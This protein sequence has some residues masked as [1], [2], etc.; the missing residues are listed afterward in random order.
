[1]KPQ[2]FKHEDIPY[3]TMWPD[4]KLWYSLMLNGKYFNGHFKF[5]GLTK[6]LD[7]NIDEII[8]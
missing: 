4:D 3:D 8:T 2:W 7:Y 5:E 1:M 6:L